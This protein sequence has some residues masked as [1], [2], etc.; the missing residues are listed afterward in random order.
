MVTMIF[1]LIGFDPLFS[2]VLTFE[3][4]FLLFIPCPY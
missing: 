4:T 2:V 1:I 3:S